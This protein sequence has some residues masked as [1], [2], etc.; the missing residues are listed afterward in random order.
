M[1]VLFLRVQPALLASYLGS[2]WVC[3][4]YPFFASSL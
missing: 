4:K 1:I 3:L 2:L